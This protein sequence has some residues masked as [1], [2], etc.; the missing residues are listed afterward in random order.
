LHLSEETPQYNDF[1]SYW[2]WINYREH[3]EQRKYCQL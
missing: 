1:I 3:K 2:I